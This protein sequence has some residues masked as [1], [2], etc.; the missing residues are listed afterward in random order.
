MEVTKTY[1]GMVLQSKWLSKHRLGSFTPR[2]GP[3][4]PGEIDYSH[5][6]SSKPTCLRCCCCFHSGY[7]PIS[8]HFCLPIH[9]KCT[10][11]FDEWL[12]DWVSSFICMVEKK[13]ESVSDIMVSTGLHIGIL[14]LQIRKPGH[15]QCCA[16][17]SSSQASSQ[18]GYILLVDINKNFRY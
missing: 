9:W 11:G 1:T 5:H 3:V 6:Q 10:Q 8:I 14:C 7:H 4:W 2:Q 16:Q 15:K 17:A 12:T 13:V 18:Q